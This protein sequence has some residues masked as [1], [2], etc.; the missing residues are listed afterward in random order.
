MPLIDPKARQ[1]I[2]EAFKK[3][4][5]SIFSK[6]VFIGKKPGSEGQEPRFKRNIAPEQQAK[7]NQEFHDAVWKDDLEGIKAALRK[8]AEMDVKNT[9]GH[10]ALSIASMRGNREVAKFLIDNGAEI[11]TKDKN[12]ATPLMHAA[13]RNKEGVVELLLDN[14]AEVDAQDEEGRTALMAAA[15]ECGISVIGIL[16]DNGAKVDARD[17][18]GRTALLIAAE[19]QYVDAVGLAKGLIE[20][21]A[22]PN[23]KNDA[24]RVPL[25][26]AHTLKN[27]DM[28]KFMREHGAK[29]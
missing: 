17:K 28:A 24:G 1:E 18:K 7:F 23:A 16:I 21:G 8:G 11:E 22:D 10:I 9:E 27:G 14:Y 15:S 2:L 26:L 3:K 5:S 6:T 19:N 25:D 29:W 12:G 20:R 4:D 13:Q